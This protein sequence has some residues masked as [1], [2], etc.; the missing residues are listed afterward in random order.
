MLDNE[1][2]PS[3]W[4]WTFPNWIQ[5][6]SKASIEKTTITDNICYISDLLRLSP[7]SIGCSGFVYLHQVSSARPLARKVFS[8]NF[9]KAGWIGYNL[10]VKDVG[11]TCAVDFSFQ[12]EEAVIQHWPSFE[13]WSMIVE[14][15]SLS[16]DRLDTKYNLESNTP[17]SATGLY[18]VYTHIFI[19]ILLLV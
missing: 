1:H 12:V 19:C 17:V 18:I 14:T 8:L 15:W 2:L 7:P 3:A 11:K 16:P 9:S 13:Y 6:S 10:R 5:L 4:S